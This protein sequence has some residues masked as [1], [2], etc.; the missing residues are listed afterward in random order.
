LFGLL[1]SFMVLGGLA[2]VIF[3]G[4]DLV[5]LVSPPSSSQH[6]DGV[7]IRVKSVTC[8][9]GSGSN[10][11]TTT[12]HHPVVRFVTDREEVIEFTSN[13]DVGYGVGD[14][15]RVRYDSEIRA[16]RGSTRSGP[17]SDPESL[18]S[19]WSWAASFSRSSAACFSGL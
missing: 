11:R 5:D 12:C 1:F 18:T 15:V 4:H 8:E 3:G 13:L 16:M 19:P 10:R 6:A 9:K 17:G 2:L 7:V 14:S